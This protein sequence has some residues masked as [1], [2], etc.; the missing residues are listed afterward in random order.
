MPQPQLEM[1]LSGLETEMRRAD[2][3]CPH[4]ARGDTQIAG[5]VRRIPTTLASPLSRLVLNGMNTGGLL[6]PGVPGAYSGSAAHVDLGCVQGAQGPTET[7]REPFQCMA[8]ESTRK[9]LGRWLGCP[10]L[11][12]LAPT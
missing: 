9:E 5:G 2:S 6:A 4:N 8:P 12:S 10:E 1:L 3:R 7:P 11:G